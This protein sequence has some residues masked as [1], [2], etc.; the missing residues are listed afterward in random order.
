M[1]N[2]CNSN[3]GGENDAA[4]AAEGLVAHSGK[5]AARKAIGDRLLGYAGGLRHRGDRDSP[6]LRLQ[7]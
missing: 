4:E 6:G 5:G 2:R 3:S 1:S 7:G